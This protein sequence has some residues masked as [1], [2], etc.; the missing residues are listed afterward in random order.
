MMVV[1]SILAVACIFMVYVLVEFHLEAKR[2]RRATPRLPRGV[3][4]FRNGFAVKPVRRAETRQNKI[5]GGLESHVVKV[6]DERPLVL[7]VG[8]R[9]LG[10]KRVGRS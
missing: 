9:R 2:P 3:I 10:A 5:I 1:I 6:S 8:I 4:L 7:P